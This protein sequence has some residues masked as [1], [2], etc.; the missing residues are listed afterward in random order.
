MQ[1]PFSIDHVPHFPAVEIPL[2]KDRPTKE[3]GI[4]WEA[5]QREWRT[6]PLWGLADSGPYLHDGRAESIDEAIRWHGGE[7]TESAE[8]YRDMTNGNRDSLLAFFGTLTSP[9]PSK[10]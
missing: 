2:K 7:A 6:P 1:T 3:V 10:F 9:M 8:K 5:L 4:T